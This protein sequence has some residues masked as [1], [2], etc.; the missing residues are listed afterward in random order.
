M[1]SYSD[2]TLKYLKKNT[3]RK[4]Y[5]SGQAIHGKTLMNFKEKCLNI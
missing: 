3:Q 1:K 2:I 5:I 4:K